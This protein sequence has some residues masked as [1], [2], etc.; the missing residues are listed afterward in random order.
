MKS[1]DTDTKTPEGS[2]EHDKDIRSL[3][4]LVDS[5]AC[6]SHNQNTSLLSQA[7]INQAH[8]PSTHTIHISPNI[9]SFIYHPKFY[10]QKES[11]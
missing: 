10:H 9:S 11:Q 2:S 3:Q 6:V 5:T 7:L 1:K 8:I 4:V